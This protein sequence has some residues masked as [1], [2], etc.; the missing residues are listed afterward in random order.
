M[1][2][3]PILST[4]ILVATISTFLLAIGAYILYKI[5][6]RKYA[7]ISEQRPVK[8]QAEVVMP[9]EPQVSYVTPVPQPGFPEKQDQY[10]QEKFV[11]TPQPSPAAFTPKPKEF[12]PESAKAEHPPK[13]K[14]TGENKFLKYTTE[15]YVAPKED[16]SSGT[17]KWR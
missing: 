5:R 6:E 15:G 13:K 2:L 17:V 12:A 11:K 4:I 3:I 8:Y 7:T 16:K 14:L 9:V 1:E 10:S